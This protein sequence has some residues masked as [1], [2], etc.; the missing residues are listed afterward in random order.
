MVT[1]MEARTACDASFDAARTYAPETELAGDP[2]LNFMHDVFD[3]VKLERE[4]A[5]D[6]PE[7]FFERVVDNIRKQPSLLLAIE[8]WSAEENLIEEPPPADGILGTAATEA[9][10]M[11]KA[12][13]AARFGKDSE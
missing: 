5:S 3:V 6:Y 10:R 8:A 7:G 4:S 12:L 2:V 11:A 1:V 13:S 9:L